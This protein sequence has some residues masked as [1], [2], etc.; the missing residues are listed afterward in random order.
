MIVLGSYPAPISLDHIARE[1]SV[2]FSSVYRDGREFAGALQ[3]LARGLID[4]GPLTTAV[5]PLSQHEKAFAALRDPEQAVKVFL[6]PR[7]ES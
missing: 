2:V 3:M 4:T 1:A 7:P 6:D 5:L